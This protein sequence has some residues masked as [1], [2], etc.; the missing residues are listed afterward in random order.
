MATLGVKNL[1]VPMKPHQEE[2]RP[3]P[4]MVTEIRSFAGLAGFV[5]F[6]VESTFHSQNNTNFHKSI[7]FLCD[8][9]KKFH[10]SLV[11][12]SEWKQP[13]EGIKD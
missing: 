3:K 1:M 9:F 4:K 13:I 6:C 12:I 8:I 2:G 10:F 7:V 11:N 5:S